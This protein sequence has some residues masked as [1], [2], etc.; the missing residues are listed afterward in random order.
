MV[1]DD[2]RQ[3]LISYLGHQASKDVP[4]LVELVEEQRATL[5]ALVDGVSEEQAAFQAAPDQWSIADVLRHVIAAEEGVA[6][7]VESLA[8]GLVPEGQRALGSHIPDEGQPLAA[9]VGRLHAARRDLLERVQAWPASPDL[10]TTFEHPFFGPLN[11]KGWVAFQRLHDAD[12]IGQLEQIKAA[13][14]YPGAH[15]S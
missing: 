9:L 1:T 6:L 3:R 13:P 5:L 8:R 15:T 10:A 7:I 4:V 11:C 14:G 12:H 2:A